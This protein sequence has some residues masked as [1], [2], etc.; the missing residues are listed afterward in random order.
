MLTV[1]RQV[2]TLFV[3]F[4][5]AMPAHAGIIYASATLGSGGGGSNGI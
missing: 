2:F 1:A 3:L 5:L 4:G